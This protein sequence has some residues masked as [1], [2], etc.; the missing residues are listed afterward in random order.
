MISLYHLRV[1]HAEETPEPFYVEGNRIFKN[2]TRELLSGK[3][4]S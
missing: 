2:C 4:G 1:C 3:V